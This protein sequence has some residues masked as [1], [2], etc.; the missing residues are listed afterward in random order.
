MFGIHILKNEFQIPKSETDRA[1][2]GQQ[3]I[4]EEAASYFGEKSRVPVQK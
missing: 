4:I 2:A 3:T 1:Q